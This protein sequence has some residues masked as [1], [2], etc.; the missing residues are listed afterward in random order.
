MGSGHA[1][2]RDGRTVDHA[3]NG[4]DPQAIARDFDWGKTSR[5]AT[6]RVVREWE[7]YAARPAIAGLKKCPRSRPPS[8]PPTTSVAPAATAPSTCAVTLASCSAE[9]IGPMSVAASSGSPYAVSEPAAPWTRRTAWPSATST[10][11]SSCRIGTADSV[12]TC[13]RLVRAG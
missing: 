5:L 3:A 9:A 7:L 4:F 6:G 1:N 10:A 2:F 12:L 11:G 8:P 13:V